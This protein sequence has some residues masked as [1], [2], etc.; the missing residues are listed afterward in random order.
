[1]KTLIN[2]FIKKI[3]VKQLT[4]QLPKPLRNRTVLW[5]HLMHHITIILRALGEIDTPWDRTHHYSDLKNLPNNLC[6]LLLV[7][8][9]T[10][11]ELKIIDFNIQ[12]ELE[13][14]N[15][16]AQFEKIKVKI[17]QGDGEIGM[18]NDI[19][20]MFKLHCF[21]V[22]D[23]SLRGRL[24]KLHDLFALAFSEDQQ[25]VMIAWEEKMKELFYF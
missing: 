20:K 18:M 11:N 15:A 5:L 24:Y 12:V 25:K 3:K 21:R 19:I 9:D 1:M 23:D 13:K 17:Q 14:V 6:D 2:N 10:I 22:I 4:K 7:P 16:Q 8:S